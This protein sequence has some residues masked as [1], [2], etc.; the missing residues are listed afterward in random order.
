MLCF[1][2]ECFLIRSNKPYQVGQTIFFKNLINQY[3]WFSSF[4]WS[5]VT[6]KGLFPKSNSGLFLNY[7]YCLCSWHTLAL[8]VGPS[9]G[10]TYIPEKFPDSS[11]VSVGA[12]LLTSKCVPD[13]VSLLFAILYAHVVL[14]FGALFIIWACL[15]LVK[16]A[17]R[18]YRDAMMTALWTCGIK[19][20]M[21]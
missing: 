16:R 15:N 4:S 12:G 18:V 8:S 20:E 14:I 3:R 10:S 1:R 9:A 13:D 6:V 11:S 5:I 19:A 2:R 21:V 17:S 7:N